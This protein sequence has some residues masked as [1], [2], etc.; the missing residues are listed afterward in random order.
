MAIEEL[1]AALSRFITKKL[2]QKCITASTGLFCDCT[3]QTT[4]S[5]GLGRA[6]TA[7]NRFARDDKEPGRYKRFSD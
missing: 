4:T 3:V 7:G 2:S 1:R 6:R 5:S